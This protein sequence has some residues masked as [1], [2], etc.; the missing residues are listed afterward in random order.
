VSDP[1]NKHWKWQKLG[2]PTT[3]EPGT[4]TAGGLPAAEVDYFIQGT[5]CIS[6]TF[7]ATGIGGLIY[8]SSS[9]KTVPSPGAYFCWI[10]LAAPNAMDTEANRCLPDC[11]VLPRNGC[12]A[13][14]DLELTKGLYFS[15]IV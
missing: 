10:Y 4:D 3:S 15:Q 14:R 12:R 8:N 7:N 6:K 13:L 5:G 11:H 2:T 1:E 9:G